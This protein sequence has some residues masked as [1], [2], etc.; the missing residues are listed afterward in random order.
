MT[1]VA[2][3]YSCNQDCPY[4]F[5]KDL[6]MDATAGEPHMVPERFEQALDFLLRSGVGQARLLG[7]EPTLHPQFALWVKAA[8]RHG[9]KVLVFSNGVMPQQ[10]LEI[11]C[12]L[13][14][15]AVDVII[16]TPSGKH[17]TGQDRQ[18]FSA[19]L[20]RLGPRARLGFN[21]F[22]PSADAGFLLDLIDAHG[23]Q[24]RIRLG[25]AHP[26]LAAKNQFLHP[27][28]YPAVGASILAL[29]DKAVQRQVELDF[30]CGFVPC[31]FPDHGSGLSPQSAAQI[32]K[33]CNPIPDILPDGRLT[34]CFALS[35]AFS[36]PMGPQDTAEK[37]QA[38]LGEGLLPYRHLGIY[39]HCSLCAL[40]AE[41]RCNG[42]C[43]AA[44]MQRL[45]PGPPGRISRRSKTAG[46]TIIVSNVDKARPP[47]TSAPSLPVKPDPG[48]TGRWILPYVDQPLEFWQKIS[49][50]YAPRVR[51]VYFPLPL[52]GIGSGRPSQPMKHLE[53][54]LRKAPFARGVLINPITLPGTVQGWAPAIMSNLKK[55]IEEDGISSVTLA[56]ASLGAMLRER[57]GQLNLTAS[58]LMDIC[59]PVQIAMLD[60]IF[61]C[62]V[63][64]SRLV[65]DLP[66]LKRLRA[67]FG[68]KLRLIV[69]EACLPGC[70]FR[71]QHFYE[72]AHL[73]RAPRSLC[74]DLLAKQPWLSLT[75]AWVLPQHLHLYSGLCDEWKLAGRVTL[76]DPQR[77][78]NVLDAYLN[79]TPLTP[80]RIGGGPAS[81]MLPISIEREFFEHTLNCRGNCHDCSLC[82]DY[83]RA[84]NES[85]DGSR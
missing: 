72:M 83:Y 22:S 51:E 11:L 65:R 32:G 63:A 17:A 8:V 76:K 23:L 54:F 26:G 61:D 44:A 12:T 5:A 3:T 19:V 55:L 47:E 6:T 28:H 31:M 81:V 57:F 82:R 52:A 77:Y 4:C 38:R 10:A 25:L 18:R 67:A 46:R 40:K 60:G 27:R 56:N 42:G 75:G 59:E 64:A 78:L 69:N 14:Q 34:A 43:L 13:P 29:Q 36:L 20:D 30:D 2:L 24:R 73:A 35:A 7:G 74:R 1:N 80:D 62:I 37:V 45:R 58:V 50:L 84:K 16:N 71:A 21:I 41:G 66:G 79:Q 70:P 15:P 48:G 85:V 53:T 49:E 33:R 68:G 9:L 39:R